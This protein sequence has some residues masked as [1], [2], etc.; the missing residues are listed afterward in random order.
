MPRAE[1]VTIAD[2]PSSTPITPLLLFSGLVV[3]GQGEYRQE[4]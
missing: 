3:A 1:P 4:V 2:L